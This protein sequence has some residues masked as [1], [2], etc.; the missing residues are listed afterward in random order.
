MNPYSRNCSFI[1][2]VLKPVTLVFK[3]LKWQTSW[4]RLC[5]LLCRHSL[6]IIWELEPKMDCWASEDAMRM[7]ERDTVRAAPRISLSLLSPH[8]WCRLRV[9]LWLSNGKYYDNAFKCRDVYLLQDL[10]ESSC[11]QPRPPASFLRGNGG[12]AVVK[13][14]PDSCRSRGNSI[15]E[16]GLYFPLIVVKSLPT[17]EAQGHSV[18]FNWSFR[19]PGWSRP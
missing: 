6:T 17:I 15:A 8:W 9:L 10:P 18:L 2:L 12:N 3:A 5:F 4:E 7:E 1:L 11:L 19:L 14:G 13:Q 16:T